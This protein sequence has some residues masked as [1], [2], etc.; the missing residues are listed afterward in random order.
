M[1][2][3][4]RPTEPS[5]SQGSAVDQLTKLIQQAWPI[6]RW[7]E[8]PVVVAV[9]GGP[10]SVAMLRSLHQLAQQSSPQKTNLIV[11][12]FNHQTRGRES[13]QDQ[14]FVK[15]LAE[16]L[17]LPFVGGSYRV[18]GNETSSTSEESLRDARYDFLVDVA[19]QHQARYIAF[20][21]HADDQVETIL[22]RLIR[23]TGLAGL[24]G[25]PFQRVIDETIT[26][27]RPLLGVSPQLIQEAL[28]QWQQASR[29]DSSNSCTDYARNFLRHEIVPALSERFS[30]TF[31][32]S[33]LRL[34]TQA[35]QQHEFIR[36]QAK[37]LLQHVG[38]NDEVV[39][40]D[41]ESICDNDVVVVRQLLD[42]I[43]TMQGWVK[44]QMTFQ[45]YD[46]VANLLMH[47]DQ[48]H[49]GFHLPGKISCRKTGTKMFLFV[50]SSS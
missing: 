18:E 23:G 46:T 37:P 47:A 29:Q 24:R 32:P 5:A 15:A 49:A 38:I 21:H 44:S 2:Q 17:A 40:I 35:A 7:L 13:D 28:G 31:V 50:D 9:S 10:D 27:V 8:F 1:S 4:N 14:A 20:G 25:I 11:A 6:N 22:F 12:H 26:V 42:E 43:W 41:C 16:S 45:H 30:E 39:E 36:A 48:S 3:T 34:G 19:R 33:V